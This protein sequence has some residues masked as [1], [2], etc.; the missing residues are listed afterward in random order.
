M[1]IQIFAVADM[2]SALAVADP[3]TIVT[4]INPPQI[5]VLSGSDYI[6]PLINPDVKGFI[7]AGLNALGISVAL[8]S[9]NAPYFALYNDALTNGRWTDATTIMRTVVASGGLTT[10]QVTTLQNL[11]SQY[12]I[13][14][15]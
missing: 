5:I 9:A 15:S 2:S 10:S 14:S 7:S 4:D 13:P 6:A 12:N 3:K 1:S 8:S 11:M